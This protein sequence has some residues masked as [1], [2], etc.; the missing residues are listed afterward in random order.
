MKISVKS[1]LLIGLLSLCLVGYA[2]EKDTVKKDSLVKAE[3]QLQPDVEYVAHVEDM[4]TQLMKDF[5]KG[6]TDSTE[7]NTYNLPHDSI[8]I[9]DDSTLK[10]RLAIL[11]EQTPFALGYNKR[12]HAFVNLYAVK[13]RELTSK[14]M[15]LSQLYFPLI[16]EILDENDMPYELKYLAVVESALNPT[17]RS[18][19]GAKG[20]W[21]FMYTT[22]RLYGLTVNSYFDERNDPYKSTR[23][24]CAYL[25]YLNGIYDDWNLALAAYNCGPGN[26]N[27]AI[28]RSGGKKDYWEIYPYL[29]RETRGYVPAFIAVNYIF[30]YGAEHNI[31]PRNQPIT[32]Y[33]TD[34]IHVTNRISFKH[35]AD[36]LDLSA[37]QIQYLNPEYKRGV[38]PKDSKSHTLRLP[39]GELALYLVNEKR[40]TE[41][42]AEPIDHS[43][44]VLAAQEQVEIYRVRN[45]DYLG[46]IANRYGVSVRNIKSWNGL[47]SDNLRVGQRLT[48][49]SRGSAP[50]AKKKAVDL[51]KNTEES[52]QFVYYKIQKGDTL[53]DIAKAK[54]ISTKELKLLNNNLN[55]KNL[56][57][58]DK[59]IIS[60]KS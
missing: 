21:Q 50:V 35:L 54:G 30:N 48:I 5:N 17:A 34:T 6:Y 3:L 1:G 23:A 45:G 59:I 19:A 40:I 29:P 41:Q 25:S 46:K 33:E 28:R 36:V 42:Y 15:G 43:E 60:K 26:V 32:F 31:Y 8:P 20:L 38:I 13:R 57:P 51:K 2:G 7:L 14:T 16:E 11:N 53:W 55:A 39:K 22:G 49:Y 10:S 37:E 12:V 44:E 18:R 27:K 24:A 4:I 47:R 52:D 56:K 9:V 58:G